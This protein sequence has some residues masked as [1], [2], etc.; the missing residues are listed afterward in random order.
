MHIVLHQPEI[1]GNT[2]NISRLCVATNTDLHL[3]GRLG[4]NIDD[5]AVKRAGLDYWPHLRLHLHGNLDE[6]MADAGETARFFYLTTKVER[7]YT[8]ISYQPDDYLVFGSESSGLPE[9]LLRQHA[10]RCIT[11]PMPGPVRSLNL[12]SAAAIVLYEALR[13]NRT[14]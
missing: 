5:K 4:F 13:Q 9:P 10:D 11:I 8:A 7:P 6:L 1:P 2:G 12:S 3:V 14:W